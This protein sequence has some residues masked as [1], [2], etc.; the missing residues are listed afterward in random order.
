MKILAKCDPGFA[1]HAKCMN[2]LKVVEELSRLNLDNAYD[3]SNTS[4]L[5]A[6]CDCR[7]GGCRRHQSSHGHTPEDDHTMEEA[8]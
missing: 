3:A 8:S 1:I 7:V 2:A 4:E 6:E 5:A